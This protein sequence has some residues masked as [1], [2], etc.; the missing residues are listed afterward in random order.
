MKKRTKKGGQ[1]F[2]L[3]FLGLLLM[4]LG[5]ILMLWINGWNGKSDFKLAVI[6]PDGLGIVS[7]SPGRG[8]VNIMETEGVVPIWIPG[9]L[10]WYKANKVDRL[11]KQEVKYTDYKA[12]FYYN[13][14]FIADKVVFLANFDDWSK[15][16]NLISEMGILGWGRYLFWQN[17]VVISSEKISGELEQD[18]AFLDEVMM[19][20]F[21]DDGILTDDLRL[22]IYNSSR[23]TGLATFLSK[24]LEW[25]GFLVTEINNSED[26]IENC[27]L[28]YS[29]IISKRESLLI[30]KE[31]FD[32]QAKND[33]TM[34]DNE[35]YLYLGDGFGQMLKYSNYV[36][37]F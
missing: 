2:F 37:S 34:T 27:L 28:A 16:R 7:V 11:L 10:G 13:F 19:R 18:M 12:I 14:G 29:P 4:F 26:K 1:W 23:E 36:R 35:V 24:R 21:G 15:N 25:A 5:L 17:N 6:F 20:D 9:G 22:S 8:M 31:L 30:L 32:C 3:T 33:D